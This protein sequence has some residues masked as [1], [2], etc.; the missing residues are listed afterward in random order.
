VYYREVKTIMDLGDGLNGHP[1]ICHGGFVAT[2]L[3]EVCGVLITLNLEKK[4]QVRMD[5]HENMNTFTACQSFAA[6]AGLGRNWLAADLNTNY[7]KPVPA[8]GI[9]LCTA[10]FVRK[11]RNKIYV[12]ASIENGMGTVYTTGEGMFVEVKQKL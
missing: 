10:K 1:N 8:P 9:L 4:M 5:P 11:E 2:M 3:D 6:D 7:K 12:A